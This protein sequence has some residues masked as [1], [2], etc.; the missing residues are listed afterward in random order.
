MG[1]VLLTGQLL[2]QRSCVRRVVYEFAMPVIKKRLPVL[3]R[4]YDH[5]CL[6]LQEHP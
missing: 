6:V 1:C 4:P 5:L 2:M 3:Q